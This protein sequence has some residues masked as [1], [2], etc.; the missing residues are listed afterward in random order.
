M[1]DA[2]LQDHIEWATVVRGVGTA[3]W[4]HFDLRV[5]PELVISAE[6]QLLTC[7]TKTADIET[8]LR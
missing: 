5:Y 3:Q 1:Q 2:C 8:P 6:R 7:W 4:G